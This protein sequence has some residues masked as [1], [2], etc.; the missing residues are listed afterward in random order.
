MEQRELVER[1]RRGDGDAF[2]ALVGP[3]VTDMLRLARLVS[4][5][6]A[7]AEDIVQEALTRVLR[8]LNRFDADRPF[9]PWFAT[10][11][12][13][14]ARNWNRSAGRRKR[15]T[16]RIAGLAQVGPVATDEQVEAREQESSIL[17]SVSLLDPIDREVLGLRF[18]L[19]LSERE[20]AETL[21]CSLGTVKSRTSR[22]L[23]RLRKKI[24]NVELEGPDDR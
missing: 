14:Q 4:G 18:L 13:N 1:A 16:L 8:S 10:I 24:P 9:R 23:D 7:D 21:Q 6:H 3:H 17:R 5:A 12:S 2:A 11:V 20:T 19:G 15:L 22:A